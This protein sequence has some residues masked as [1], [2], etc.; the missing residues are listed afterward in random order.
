MKFKQ[1]CFEILQPADNY[2]VVSKTFDLTITVLIIVNIVLIVMD[3]FSLPDWLKAISSGAEVFLVAIFTIEYIVRVYV[4]DMLYPELTP[5]KARIKYI[6]SALALI[7]LLA[8]L[9][10]YIPFIIPFDLR[11]LRALRT[12]RLLRIFKITRYTTALSSIVAVL[13]QKKYELFSSIAVV[14]L[15]MVIA[16]VIMYSVENEA[17]PD[18]F[19]N[20]FSALW[21]AFATLTTVGY[22]DIYPITVVGKILSTII[23]VLGIGLVA[24]PTGIISAGFTE[25]TAHTENKNHCEKT[26]CPYCGNKID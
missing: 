23:A 15:L 24:I 7:D 26:F 11:A 19:D 8:I 17:Q 5:H 13:K 1:R 20:A 21:W 4:S 18:V 10:F 2:N 12:I 6:F 3:T 25:Q 22:G 16:A 9:P 14:A